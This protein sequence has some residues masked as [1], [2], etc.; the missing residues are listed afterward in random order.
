MKT[1]D[2][3]TVICGIW[4]AVRNPVA[5]CQAAVIYLALIVTKMNTKTGWMTRPF[6]PEVTSDE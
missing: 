1:V 5:P 6:N 3:W 4:I 2:V